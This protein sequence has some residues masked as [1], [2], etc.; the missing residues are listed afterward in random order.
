[1]GRPLTRRL[2]VSSAIVPLLGI[3]T[4]C[5]RDNIADVPR[6]RPAEVVEPEKQPKGLRPPP[7]SSAGMPYDPGGPAPK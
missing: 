2:F 4:G 5:E 6:L 1:M 3:A 7:G